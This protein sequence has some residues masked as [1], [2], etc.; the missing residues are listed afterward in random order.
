[1]KQ[2]SK[3]TYY[4]IF[5]SAGNPFVS[6][7]FIN[8]N[9]DKVSELLFLTESEEKPSIGI[10]V[11]LQDNK[12]LSPFSAPFG[13]F[14]YLH[15]NIYFSKI[16][17]FICELRDFILTNNYEEFRCVLPPS[18]YGGSFNSKIL[19]AMVRNGFELGAVELTSFVEILN[20][21]NRFPVKS[22]REYYNQA[23]K[24][25]LKLR[26]V[27]TSEEKQGIINIVKENRESKN[28]SLKMTFTDFLN[29]ESFWEV[30]YLGVFHEDSNAMVGGG[31]FY[32]FP[33]SEVVYTAIWGDSI[34][35]RTFRAMDY[36]VFESVVYYQK[37]GI[38]YLDLG[39]ST[40]GN[41][42]PNEG[43]LRFKE[44]HEAKTEP[45][46]VINLK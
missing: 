2:L 15:E 43:L 24:Y 39:I 25:G 29:L 12:L 46:F 40:E 9:A 30:D 7:N 38:K 4:T 3:E 11:G 5:K 6:E 8:L 20:F 41:G 45:R 13:G 14:H 31:I 36:L 26:K 27:E 28:R 21:K 19:N 35:G 18:I 23:V 22:S 10:V 37:M 33:N 1:M 42:I 16:E 32:R 44:T 34:E 17:Q